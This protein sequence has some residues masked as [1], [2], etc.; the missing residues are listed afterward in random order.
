MAIGHLHEGHHDGPPQGESVPQ[1][2]E[3]SLFYIFQCFKTEYECTIA[4]K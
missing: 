1:N 4:K 3:G 2:Q